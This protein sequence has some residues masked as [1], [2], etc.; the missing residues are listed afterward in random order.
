[1]NICYHL[2]KLVKPIMNE[3]LDLVPLDPVPL[4]LVSLEQIK[5]IIE[6]KKWY[7]FTESGEFEWG[8]SVELLAAFISRM[9]SHIEPQQIQ[10]VIEDSFDEEALSKAG[11]EYFIDCLLQIDPNLIIWSEGD[12]VW[13]QF[14][15]SKT[16]LL[17]RSGLKTQFISK[18]KTDILLEML[19][20]FVN[21]NEEKICVVIIDDKEKNFLH[22]ASLQDQV[23]NSGIE[24]KTFHLNLLDIEA[25]PTACLK[26][27]FEI[28]KSN[29][30]LIVDMDGVLVNTN[31]VL[32][33][34]D[35]C[36]C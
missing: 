6:S 19:M 4:D 18:S 22:V 13:Q 28:K 3:S 36:D 11:S 25:N 12:P 35:K 15:A 17:N 10:K 1:M 5:I 20:S 9:I 34:F 24:I 27:L 30:R 33:L 16:G 26:F 31:L 2:G 7:A 21:K 32:A 14:K 8:K 29:I 23:A